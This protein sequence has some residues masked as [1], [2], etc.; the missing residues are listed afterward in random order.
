[1]CHSANYFN[2]NYKKLLE[3]KENPLNLC[4]LKALLAE[5]EAYGKISSSNLSDKADLID[6]LWLLHAESS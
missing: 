2:I 6:V 4:L 3:E 1:M 5:T